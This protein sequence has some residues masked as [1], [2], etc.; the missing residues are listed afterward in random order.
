MRSYMPII[1]SLVFS[2]IITFSTRWLLRRTNKNIWKINFLDLA[3]K[4]LPYFTFTLLG[5]VTLAVR[6]KLMFISPLLMTILS[7]VLVSCLILL[8]TL[9]LSLFTGFISSMLDKS[10]KRTQKSEVDLGRR[11]FLKAG[12]AALPAVLISSTGIGF[13]GGF[14][15]VRIPEVPMIFPD[16]P[17]ALDG[18]RILHLSDLHL[19]YYYQLNDLEDLLGRMENKNIDLVLVTGDLSDDL[20][21]LPD[22]LKLIEQLK[23]KNPKFISIGN[24]EYFRGVDSFL[25]ETEKSPLELLRNENHV[26][27]INGV[28]VVLA[29]ADDPVA[30][31]S[32]IRE[33]MYKTVA[34]SMQNASANAFKLLMSHRPIALDRAEEFDIDLILAGHTHGGQIGFNRR[35]VFEDRLQNEHYLWGKFQ[36]GKSQLYTS[37]GVGHWF[38]FRLG[39]PAEAPIIILKKA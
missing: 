16:L 17:E 7:V 39:C 22:A 35:S 37:S 33:F 36:K 19:G 2:T 21:R 15:Q 18:L 31:N 28:P 1:V 11:N 26:I 5:M 12:S 29:G 27:D 23:T 6:F 20:N 25:K 9:P 14:Q 3:G 34:Q 10:K 8:V 4:Y 32:D 38:P 24:H 30:L 13:A